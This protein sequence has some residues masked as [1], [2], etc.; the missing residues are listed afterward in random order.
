M[1]ARAYAE[2]LNPAR[3]MTTAEA[4][5][6]ALTVTVG[7]LAAIVALYLV[8]SALGINLLP[9]PSPFHELLYPLVRG[10]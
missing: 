3:A 5:L 6:L 7:G 10:Y 8:K 9:G 4:A 2:V 1:L